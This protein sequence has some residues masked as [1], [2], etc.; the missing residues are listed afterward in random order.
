M[1]ELHV[2]YLVPS[3]NNLR[4]KHWR[5]QKKDRD[6]AQVAVRSALRSI[7]AQVTTRKRVEIMSYRPRRCADKGNLEAGCKSLNDALTSH[8]LI[9]DDSIEWCHFIYKQELASKSPTGKPMT[10]VRIYEQTEDAE[11]EPQ[12]LPIRKKRK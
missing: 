6:L 7:G 3:A 5:L 8:G 4:W 10:L 12:T 11:L 2:P 9:K 1:L